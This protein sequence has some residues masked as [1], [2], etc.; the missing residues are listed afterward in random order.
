MTQLHI[1][2]GHTL[3]GIYSV[4]SCYG[5]PEEGG[6][7]YD[8]Y[9]PVSSHVIPTPKLKE[10]EK[11]VKELKEKGP[12]FP[13]GCFFSGQEDAPMI[14]GETFGG[15]KLVTMEEEYPGE[16]DNTGSKRPHYS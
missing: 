4:Q 16:F 11:E 5:G 14:V 15:S 8:E 6:W 9:M 2:E 7:W 10:F 3:V 12:E 13:Q 1:P